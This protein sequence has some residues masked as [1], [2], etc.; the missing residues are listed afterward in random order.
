V[1]DEMDRLVGNLEHAEGKLKTV[2]S[3]F[4]NIQQPAPAPTE[5]PPEEAS[6]AS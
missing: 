3:Y 2:I 4:A 1:V 6:D 5:A